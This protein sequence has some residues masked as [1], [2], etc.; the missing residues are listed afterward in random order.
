MSAKFEL[1]QRLKDMKIIRATMEASSVPFYR[2]FVGRNTARPVSRIE[3]TTF[4]SIKVNAVTD[5][6][7]SPMSRILS[8]RR[9]FA[10][11]SRLVCQVRPN[12]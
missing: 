5:A 12:C 2:P 9:Q 10:Y 1:S 7:H 8:D 6:L 4:E 3:M 11:H